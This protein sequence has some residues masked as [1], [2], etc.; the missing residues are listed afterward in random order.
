MKKSGF[1]QSNLPKIQALI[2][3]ADFQK[4][5]AYYQQDK[6]EIVKIIKSAHIT[7]IGMEATNETI[8]SA[9]FNTEEYYFLYSLM[10]N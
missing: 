2:H 1:N 6:E 4:T 8:T 10:N 7:K 9:K 5:L 3:S